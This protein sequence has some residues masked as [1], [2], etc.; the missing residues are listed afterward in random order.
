[1]KKKGGSRFVFLPKNTEP[2]RVGKAYDVYGVIGLLNFSRAVRT[3]NDLAGIG[4][5]KTLEVHLAAFVVLHGQIKTLG[6]VQFDLD[7][8]AGCYRLGDQILGL[9]VSSGAQTDEVQGKIAAIADDYGFGH[10][11]T[12]KERKSEYGH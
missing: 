11:G 3:Q 5:I 10:G 8:I 1:M 2:A 7:A 4:Q 12:G 9:G 6:D